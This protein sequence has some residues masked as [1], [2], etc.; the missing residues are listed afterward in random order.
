MAF[1]R[2]ELVIIVLVVTVLILLI[3]PG[4]VKAREKSQLTR[5]ANN[6]VKIGKAMTTWAAGHT[7]PLTG[8]GAYSPRVPTNF[9]GSLEFAGTRQV[10]QHFRAMSNELGSTALLVCPSD[11]RE[12]GSSWLTLANTNLSYFISL[13]ADPRIQDRL[14]TGDRHLDSVSPWK[15]AMLVVSTNTTFSWRPKLHQGNSGNVVLSDGSVLQ[16]PVSSV[17]PDLVRSDHTNRLE[18]P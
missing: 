3:V 13:D 9:G 17:G 11:S 18:F 8:A 12:P 15:G 5:C 14:L 6:L 7:N 2:L 16:V 10:F 1:T 4:L